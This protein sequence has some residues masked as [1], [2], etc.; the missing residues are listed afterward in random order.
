MEFWT[1]GSATSNVSLS[2]SDI[3]CRHYLIHL[4]IFVYYLLGLF[5]RTKG[6]SRILPWRLVL[7]NVYG[8]I[9]AFQLCQVSCNSQSIVGLPRSPLQRINFSQSTTTGLHGRMQSFFFSFPCL[10]IV[11]WYVREVILGRI[12]MPSKEE[13]LSDM[14]SWQARERQV[15]GFPEAI[16]SIM[17][18]E[19]YL[20][21][22][23]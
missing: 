19:S 10:N 8:F 13:P 17:V 16:E 4:H 1:A 9:H 7:L 12:L 2:S 23:R 15:N 18:I 3:H 5:S 20:Q 21:T 22:S 11:V 14:A 6:K